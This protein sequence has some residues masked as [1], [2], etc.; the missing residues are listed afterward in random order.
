MNLDQLVHKV[1]WGH[2]DSEGYREDRVLLDRQVLPEALEDK[3][4]SNVYA[5][6]SYHLKNIENICVLTN[7][8]VLHRYCELQ[9]CVYGI[10][11]SRFHLEDYVQ[12]SM[13]TRDQ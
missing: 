1:R 4:R 6:N 5:N 3:V 10:N 12:V 11:D 2:L 13:V 7:I 9:I 8:H